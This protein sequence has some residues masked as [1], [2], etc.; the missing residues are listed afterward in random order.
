MTLTTSTSKA[1]GFAFPRNPGKT[2]SP[3]IPRR[4]QAVEGWL[5]CHRASMRHAWR[6]GRGRAG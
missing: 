1:R 2:L 6:R 3:R 4:R 5:R